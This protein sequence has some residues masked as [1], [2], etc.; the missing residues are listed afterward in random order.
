MLFPCLAF[1]AVGK[2]VG[3]NRTMLP[4]GQ[5]S[6]VTFTV[7]AQLCGSKANETEMGTA[8]FTKTGEERILIFD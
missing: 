4:D 3:M 7:L 6:T 2:S 1:S 5:P 8:L